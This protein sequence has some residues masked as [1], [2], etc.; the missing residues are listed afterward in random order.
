[1]TCLKI[2]L[3]IVSVNWDPGYQ[4]GKPFRVLVKQEM[5]GR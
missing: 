1:M 3:R 2:N 5:M 4:E